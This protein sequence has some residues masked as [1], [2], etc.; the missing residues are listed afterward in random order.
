[1]VVANGSD[2]SE[3]R[4]HQDHNEDRRLALRPK[5]LQSVDHFLL[6]HPLLIVSVPLRITWCRPLY[7]NSSRKIGHQ[8]AV[9]AGDRKEHRKSA[10]FRREISTSRDWSDFFQTT[11]K[12]QV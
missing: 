7:V 2:K 1:M 3:A 12:N 10:Q 4:Q 6:K 5:L 8:S 11:C 9:T